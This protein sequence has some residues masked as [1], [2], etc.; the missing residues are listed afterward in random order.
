MVQ[1]TKKKATTAFASYRFAFQSET[2]EIAALPDCTV[3]ARQEISMRQSKVTLLIRIRTA[4]GRQP[5][6][7]PVWLNRN[8]LNRS[9]PSSMGSRRTGPRAYITFAIPTRGSAG[10]KLLGIW[11]R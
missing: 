6:C 7:K 4:D 5:Y 8:E 2:L 11:S 3:L 9:G 1:G 10:G